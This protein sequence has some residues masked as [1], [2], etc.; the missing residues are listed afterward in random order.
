MKLWDFVIKKMKAHSDQTV[1][2]EGVTLTYDELIESAGKFSAL[3]RGEECCAIYCN[4][5]F[6][7]SIALLACF[8]AGITAVPLSYKYGDAHCKKILDL[9]SPSCIIS[10]KD[11]ELTVTKFTNHGYVSPKE[12]PALIMCTSGTTGVPKGAMLSEDNIISNVTDI[13][14]YFGINDSDRILICRPLYHCAVLTGEFLVSLIKGVKI[15]FYSKPF[16][17]IEIIK[18]CR[19]KKITVL[20]ATPTFFGMI[21]RCMR[22]EQSIKLAHIV[23]SGECMDDDI[24]REILKGFKGAKIYHVYGLTEACPRVSYMP[25]ESFYEHPGCVGIP[26]DSVEIKILDENGFCVNNGARGMLWVK[27]KNVM[28][29]Y[30]NAETETAKVLHQGWLCTGDISSIID[31]KWLK[32]HGRADDMII[33]SG[34]NIYPSEIETEMKKDKRTK[35][36]LVYALN[37][38]KFGVR[39]AM[40]ICGDFS[41]KTEV[42]KLCKQRLSD[43]QVPTVIN[44]VESLEKN[45]SGKII[46]KKTARSI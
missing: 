10:D 29:G 17:P 6:N 18:H 31:N 25:P 9:V 32:I 33:L 4:S 36:V 40:D 16:N 46:R 26:L 39:I 19:S 42:L 24:G 28:I 8:C 21:L 34:M 22:S 27:G 20:C 2:E 23:I 14:A 13:A 1:T 30:Y 35:E 44:L 45:G 37:D 15:E 38:L 43:Y 7:A 5:E 12:H 11:G 3:L 41:D